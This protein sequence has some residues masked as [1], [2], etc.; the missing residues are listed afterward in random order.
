[1]NKS[2]VIAKGKYR[3]PRD[4]KLV[5]ATDYVIVRE[6]GK[7][8]LI[9]R[10]FN[11]R[12]EIIDRLNIKLIQL[13]GEG[14]K[15]SSEH[16]GFYNVRGACCGSFVPEKKI[17]LSEGCADFKVEVLSAGYGRYDYSSVNGGICVDFNEQEER[18]YN[19]SEIKKSLGGNNLAIKRRR[20]GFSVLVCL[21]TLIIAA[22]I[23]VVTFYQVDRFKEE[24]VTFI[25]DKLQYTFIDGDKSD[26]GK[27]SITGYRGMV[28]D[29]VI[30]AEIEG[31]PVVEIAS[32]AFR[33]NTYLNSVSLMG[34]VSIGAN[35]FTNCTNL[36][37]FDFSNVTS[38]GDGAFMNC[39]SLY[40]VQSDALTFIGKE[41]FSGCVSLQNLSVNNTGLSNGITITENAF[42][43]CSGLKNVYINKDIVYSGK[44]NIFNNCVNMTSLKIA[45]L[46]TYSG[47]TPKI[48]DLFDVNEYS[49]KLQ[50][51]VINTV[52]QISD[53]M[54]RGFT[55]LRSFTVNVNESSEIGSY[56]FAYCSA[57][58]EINLGTVIT[59]VGSYAFYYCGIKGIDLSSALNIGMS[60]FKG[61]KNLSYV[62]LGSSGL[63][64]SIPFEAFSGCSSLTS[65]SVP[66]S[67][68]TIEEYAF[69]DCNS[70][71]DLVLVDGG[72]LNTIGDSAFFNCTSLTD[73]KIP[74]SVVKVGKSA[75]RNCSSLTDAVL[76]SGITSIPAY[77]FEGCI[78]LSTCKIPASVTEIGEFAF[79]DCI[80]LREVIFPEKLLRIS[81]YAFNNCQKLPSIDLPDGI[82][83]VGQGAFANCYSLESYTAPFVGETTSSNQFLSYVFGNSVNSA[84]LVPENLKKVTLTKGKYLNS[85]AFYEC[86]FLTE[87]NLPDGLTE[88]GSQAF[89]GCESLTS[90]VIPDSVI[91]VGQGAFEE[92]NSLSSLTVPFVGQ[93]PSTN[94][95]ISYTFGSNSFYINTSVMP[96]SL[97]TVTVTR[98]DALAANA[99]YGCSHIKEIN[100]P[101]NL[102]SVGDYAFSGCSSL[103]SL[104]VPDG[105]TYLGLGAFSSCNSLESLTL[106][107][108]G[109]TKDTNTYLSYNFGS[110]N[111]Y[112]YS[113]V[114]ESLKTVTV[115]NVDAL[116]KYA[117]YNCSRITSINLPD[118][119][120]SI[121]D[122]AFYYTYSLQSV[123]LPE[124]IV[125]IGDNAF[126]YNYG[127]SE[128]T[129]PQSLTSIGDYAFCGCSSLKSL[130]VPDGVTSMGLGVFNNCNSLESLTVPFVGQ[131]KDTNAYF[132]Y[133]FGSQNA[134]Y[135]NSVPESLKTVTVTSVDALAQNA[136]Y[137]CSYVTNINLPE[138]I[139]SIGDYA[140]YNTYN[141]QSVNLPE[142]IESIGRNAFYNNNALSEIT[143]PESLT[144]IGDYAFSGCILLKSLTVP[145]GVTSMGLGVFNSCNSLESLTLP[146]V[147]QSEDFNNYLA[148]NFGASYKEAY[149]RA[150]GSLKSVTVT[151][152]EILGA[153]AFYGDEYIEEINLPENLTAIR[154]NSFTGCRRLRN[155]TLPSN[156]T[157][158]ADYA[159]NSCYNLYEVRNKSSLTV[160]AGSVLCGAVAQ[161]ALK[162]YDGD[163]ER[164]PTVEQD[165]FVF[166]NP[167][168]QWYLV[169]YPY[170]S[171]EITL[172]SS[173]RYGGQTVRS[174][175][176]KSYLF[177]NDYYLKSLSV[178]S[179]VALL[180]EYAFAGVSILNTVTFDDGSKIDTIPIC[181]FSDC[182]SLASINIPESVEKIDSFAFASCTSLTQFTVGLNVSSIA[183][184]AFNNCYRLREVYNYSSL[185]VEKGSD[186]YGS[187]AKWAI[188]VYTPLSDDTRLEYV[189]ID[190]ISY[191]IYGQDCQVIGCDLGIEE[192]NID[193]FTYKGQVINNITIAA[194]A[195]E[196]N[197][198]LKS[199]SFGNVTLDICEAAFRYCYYLKYVT[200][201]STVGV[202][203]GQ[204]AFYY[205]YSLKQMALPQG[206]KNI[207][208]FA[209]AYCYSLHSVTIPESIE[210]IG[211]N[212]FYGCSILCEVINL[213]T[214]PLV[215]S[216]YSYGYVT[217]YAKLVHTSP[218][219]RTVE[220][221]GY[222]FILISETWFGDNW[223]LVGSEYNMSY[224]NGVAV[225]PTSFTYN[226][227]KITSYSLGTDIFTYSWITN[228][229]FPTSVTALSNSSYWLYNVYYEGTQEKWE[230]LTST[231]TAYDNVNVY[232]YAECVHSNG[233]WSYD[234]NGNIVTSYSTYV[235]YTDATCEHE[236]AEEYRCLLCDEVISR[237]VYGKTPHTPDSDGVCT[238]CGQEAVKIT[239]ENFSSLGFITNDPEN[240][241]T[242][243]DDGTLTSSNYTA[244]SSATLTI[245]AETPITVHFAFSKTDSSDKFTIN[246]NDVNR[247]T[248][249]GVHVNDGGFTVYELNVGDVL[250]FT[251]QCT[252]T[253]EQNEN[254]VNIQIFIYNSSEEAAE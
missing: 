74:G 169:S 6:R 203:V 218:I 71:S 135:Y 125:S 13:D 96:E 233:E 5:Y 72:C 17:E 166:V 239:G 147:G 49:L 152:A 225:L 34:S 137:N 83:S 158:V 162:V 207:G 73:V 93:T 117:F 230:E 185:G 159:F 129:L 183:S 38:V 235:T 144:S 64:T 189:T 29:I 157:S 217:W 201:D 187:I 79:S 181:C 138:G 206:V 161:Y 75:F 2:D 216:S 145:D 192:L 39:S 76:P 119:I 188:A 143:L 52:E 190:G 247:I 124:G 92:C 215:A 176:I 191:A 41:A 208:N 8:Y 33:G 249:M 56:A 243:E 66:F 132:S 251:Y 197:N 126:Y 226:G 36:S 133:N 173:F 209:F 31:Y 109:Q 44:P 113:Y 7:K 110:Q 24:E 107:F 204:E 175:N 78:H 118:S 89:Y 238:V 120:T 219:S 248:Y 199:V 246:Y 198:S 210:Q 114:P 163:E 14:E 20:L 254:C 200:F 87:I 50:E 99:F 142:G 3:Y 22:C 90:L 134:N 136:F 227:R 115:T 221:D 253:D 211:S 177:F 59:G 10:F 101:D 231:L 141:L 40:E 19:V 77:V 16:I 139:T 111:G 234:S 240:P 178:P 149:N 122:Y 229:V 128:I 164:M 25:Q 116:G 95:F 242:V 62:N 30:P 55:Y 4:E 213:S 131:T 53:S 223:Q 65:F 67:V 156:L 57:L 32:D 121:G 80:S 194:H 9:L 220:K 51:I 54:C 202:N 46:G 212:A 174:Y 27:L 228:A 214:L 150:P 130:T 205:C 12:D 112:Y 127:L 153:Y 85:G 222:V 100:L 179:S 236:G 186:D 68:N 26:S 47:L 140:F 250:Y 35:A 195:F 245:K 81:S 88:I 172:P 193:E 97:K 103:T 84:F 102:T 244:G 42:C 82:N 28:A 108:V 58:T 45:G 171:G 1:M 146:F 37:S 170:G 61:C 160:T 241:Y 86:E 182:T 196:N 184:Y 91:S 165:N 168:T 232:F 237:T 23:A 15:L 123:N 18:N 63:I 11:P 48:V 60:A 167:D 105:V 106:P 224:I 21:F 252:Q 94:G 98:A 43:N 155:I 104:T 151:K 148:Y 70:L 69:A 154:E 180:G